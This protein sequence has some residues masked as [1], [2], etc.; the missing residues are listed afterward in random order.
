MVKQV[1]WQLTMNQEVGFFHW[2]NTNWEANLKKSPSYD[3]RNTPYDVDGYMLVGTVILNNAPTYQGTGP[4]ATKGYLYACMHR[5]RKLTGF[6]CAYSI[7][8][9]AE[10]L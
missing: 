4:T 2:L 10:M 3:L 6:T 8:S 7:G 9:G 1:G 5:G